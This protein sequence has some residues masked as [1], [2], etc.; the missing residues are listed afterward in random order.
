MH[1]DGAATSSSAFC[2]RA[3]RSKAEGVKTD[4][5]DVRLLSRMGG[6]ATLDMFHSVRDPPSQEHPPVAANG[7]R[8]NP[9]AFPRL[10]ADGSRPWSRQPLPTFRSGS[11]PSRP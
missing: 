2:R 11:R 4:S 3:S 9:L 1:T 6:V 8:A 7:L 5:D 10:K